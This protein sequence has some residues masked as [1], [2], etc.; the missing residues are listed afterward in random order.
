[1]TATK[2]KSK[3]VVHIEG[4]LTVAHAA[5][6][7]EKLMQSLRSSGNI[8]IDL[9]KVT[10]IDL[11]CLQ[12]FCSAHRTAIR[13]GKEWCMSNRDN[14]V[15]IG[16]GE[17]AGLGYYTKCTFDPTVDCLWKRVEEGGTEDG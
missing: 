5:G 9:D 8:E 4:E 14:S 17:D 11:A 15:F 12:V 1:M 3:N 2:K 10:K 13:D 7:K 16:A 6:L